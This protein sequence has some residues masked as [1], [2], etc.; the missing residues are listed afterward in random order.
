MTDARL[1][2]GSRLLTARAISVGILGVVAVGTLVALA[3]RPSWQLA[4]AALCVVPC[5]VILWWGLR[6]WLAPFAP[7]VRAT[8]Y[9]RSAVPPALVLALLAVGGWLLGQAPS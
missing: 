1:L 6:L 5:P 7:G 3:T 8:T 4:L 9:L 2:T